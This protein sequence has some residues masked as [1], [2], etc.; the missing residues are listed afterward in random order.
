[1]NSPANFWCHVA[2]LNIHGQTDL[3][4]SMSIVVNGKDREKLMPWDLQAD[5]PGYSSC[6]MYD[7]NYTYLYIQNDRNFDKLSKYL[8][9]SFGGNNT[10]SH[11]VTRCQYGWDYVTLQHD[12][13]IVTEWNL[14]CDSESLLTIATVFTTISGII[15]LLTAGYIAD[16][17]GRKPTF[18]V[19]FLVMLVF[20]LSWAFVPTFVG[21]VCLAVLYSFGS[22]PLYHILYTIGKFIFCYIYSLYNQTFFFLQ[23]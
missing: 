6:L 12:A 13:S 7:V 4:N 2:E 3:N 8:N 11:S 23:L 19:F 10:H 9:N 16:R 20:A 21:F 18:F 22:W 15:G 17:W 14:V 1:M 5:P